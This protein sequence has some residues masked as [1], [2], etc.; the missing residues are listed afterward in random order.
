MSQSRWSRQEI[1]AAV[2][3]YFH[4]VKAQRAGEKLN[5]AALY[6]DLSAKNPCRSAKAFEFKFQNISAILYEMKR[7]YADGLKPLG[8]YQTDLKTHIFAYLKSHNE[9]HEHAGDPFAILLEKLKRLHSMGPVPSVAQG[10]GGVGLTLERFL[11]IPQNPSKSPDFMGIELKAKASPGNGAMSQSLQTLFSLVPSHYEDCK[12]R[13]EFLRKYGYFDPV[14]ERMALYTSINAMGDTLGFAL[15]SQGEDVKVSHKAGYALHYAHERLQDALYSKHRETAFVSAKS[16]QVKGRN[17]FHYTGVSHCR[18]PSYFRFVD[19]I[20]TGDVYLNLTLS[21]KHGRVQDHGFLWRI[22]Q[23]E[24]PALFE[25]SQ[26][27]VF[28]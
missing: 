18:S 2:E 12:D 13:R 7:P 6:R 1:A 23:E 10:P 11:A 3:G 15:R 5:K 24:I 14:K 8:N 16:E 19:L 22:R 21:E 9:D 25:H 27:I 20:D 26:T 28:G 17:Y 4:L